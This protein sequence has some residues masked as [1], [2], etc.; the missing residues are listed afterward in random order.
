MYETEIPVVSV[1]VAVE[2]ESL[3]TDQGGAVSETG[4]VSSIPISDDTEQLSTTGNWV[5]ECVKRS[6]L[7]C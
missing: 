7:C 2:T 1:P 4:G 5:E 3:R 6:S